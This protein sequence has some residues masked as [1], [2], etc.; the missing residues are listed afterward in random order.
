MVARGGHLN[1][2][3]NSEAELIGNVGRFEAKL[4]A[5]QGNLIERLTI[6]SSLDLREEELRIS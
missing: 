2:C 1:H 3:Q 5:D 6:R 4:N